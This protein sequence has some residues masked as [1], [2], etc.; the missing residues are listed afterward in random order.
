MKN[1]ITQFI[2][3]LLI[4]IFVSYPKE[5]AIFSQTVLG[6]MVF[7]S[8]ILFYTYID[9]V[10]GLFICVIFILY[11]QSAFVE[12]MLNMGDRA[13]YT[14]MYTTTSPNSPAVDKFRSENCQDGV[15]VYKDMMVK[16]D[17]A[18][19][20]F[21]ELTL[22][23]GVCNPCSQ[24]CQVSIIEGKLKTEDQVVRKIADK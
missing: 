8:I 14:N 5:V 22:P 15:L 21:P 16:N 9:V 2:P 7:I 13:N 6:K 24:N 4:F 20:I 1:L 11:S 10:W 18:E 19:H 12:N 3:I 17:M 23:G